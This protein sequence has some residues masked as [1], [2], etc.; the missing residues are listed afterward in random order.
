M[1]FEGESSQ[2][3]DIFGYPIQQL[4]IIYN[5]CYD[6]EFKVERKEQIGKEKGMGGKQ[7]DLFDVEEE[8]G[9]D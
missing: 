6:P 4:S 7:G 9:R 1:G 5:T 3:N 2:K 8:R